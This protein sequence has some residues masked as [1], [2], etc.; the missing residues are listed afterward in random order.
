MTN[1]G[2]LAITYWLDTLKIVGIQAMK[3]RIAST[4]TIA[5]PTF[6]SVSPTTAGYAYANDCE[7]AVSVNPPN[8]L[9]FGSQL[10]SRQ[11]QQ[12]KQHICAKVST[13]N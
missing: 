3:L 10:I 8:I 5:L 12:V 6:L 11:I 13:N 2:D 1:I 9:P 7:P 4:L